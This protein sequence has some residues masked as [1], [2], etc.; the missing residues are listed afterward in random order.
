V[1][2]RVSPSPPKAPRLDVYAAHK[3]TEFFSGTREI[4]KS[5]VAQRVL[6]AGIIKLYDVTGNA[7]LLTSAAAGVECLRYHRDG[8]HWY[9][10]LFT[11]IY[12]ISLSSMSLIISRICNTRQTV[13]KIKK[14]KGRRTAS[15]EHLA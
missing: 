1:Y 9:S 6:T 12:C 14:G 7:M 13:G 2:P 15:R 5:Y 10:F 4:A 8:I 3:Q 11:A